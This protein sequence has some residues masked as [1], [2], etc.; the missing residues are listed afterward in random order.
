M[1]IEKKLWIALI[2]FGVFAVAFSGWIFAR[3]TDRESLV[4]DNTVRLET[5]EKTEDEIKTQNLV[6]PEEFDIPRSLLFKTT[7]TAVEILLDGELIYQYGNEANA[8]KFMK[9][10]G[11]CWHIVDIPKDSAGKK[12]EVRI[13]PAY[14]GYYG[15]EMVLFLG[16]KGDCILKILS[17]SLPIF[18]ISCGILF[19]GLISVFLYFA[20]LKN[21]RKRK[22]EGKN[23]IF[24][25]LG[26][27]SLLIALWSL[28]QCGFMQFLIP[29]GRTLYFVDF[30][31]FFLFPVPFNFLVYDICRSKYRRAALYFPMSYLLNMAVAVLLQC[32]GIVDIF[33][34]LP[35]THVLMAGN[36]IYTFALIHYEAKAKNNIAAKEFQYPLYIVLGFGVAEMIL[37][38]ARQFQTTSIFLPLGTM[39]FIIALIWIQVS[40]YYDQYVQKQKLLYLH[41]IA[42]KD[43]LTDAMNRNAYER[44][45][46]KLDEQTL[47]LQKT[48]VVLFDLDNLKVINDNFGHEKGDEALRLCYNCIC[49]I[50]NERENCFRIGGDE[51]AYVYHSDEKELI[52]DRIKRLDKLLEEA[53]KKVSYPLSVS[54]GYAYYLPDSDSAFKD[55]AKRSDIMLYR[56]KRRKKLNRASREQT[57]PYMEKNRDE[58]V[59]ESFREKEYQEIMPEELCK[60]IDLISPS[61][62]D[63]LYLIDFR[64]DFYYIA[65]QAMERF[66]IG[67]NAFHNVMEYHRE[68]VYGPDYPL[69]KAEFA[70]L[71]STDRCAHNMEYRWMDLKREPIWINCRGYVV[72]DENMK[73][74][75]MVGC[76]N[77]IGARQK[78]DYVSGLLGET[79]LREYLKKLKPPFENG[80]LIRLGLDHFK[81]INENLGWEYGDQVLRETAVCISGCMSENQ[82]VYRLFSD[83]FMIL[84]LSSRSVKE[85]KKL[86]DKVRESVDQFIR[87]N[88]YTVMFTISGGIL[89]LHAIEEMG[90]SAAMKLTD[91]SLNEAKKLGRNRCY[92]FEEKEYRQFLRRSELKQELRNAVINDFKGFTAFYQPVFR[93]ETGKLYGAEALMRFISEKFGMVSPA[94]FIPILEETGLIIP[95]GRWM[96]GEAMGKCSQI[97]EVLPKFLV[98]IN[99]SQVQAAKSDV[100]LDVIAAME[101]AKL[102]ADALIIELTESDLLEQNIN[103]RHFLTEL[104]R[105]KIKLALDDFGTGYSNF[106]YLSELG[107]AIIKIDRSFTASAVADEGEYY[108]LNQF[109]SMI[110]NLNLKLCIEGVENKEEWSKIRNLQ[111]DFSQGF[112]W[113]RPCPYEEFVEKFVEK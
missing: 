48:G 97:R 94:E 37:Y 1:K 6:L 105:M 42:N 41:K 22:I 31:T 73:P 24:L 91:F 10:P 61:T 13:L 52:A 4:F 92:V 57:A 45:I 103:E 87:D 82:T 64:T 54:A 47:Q 72:R 68:F 16:T 98:S 95:A 106:H 74:L 5:E 35:V 56:H 60:V 49:Q 29:D 83:E 69:L 111:P 28:Q 27:F 88:E 65:P 43:M 113:G 38:Y 99:I 7:H 58:A 21:K 46:Q 86:Y 112:F 50:F 85:V 90:D 20:T 89:P 63:Y 102:P 33:Q 36:V 70:D 75:Y 2:L 23:E 53:A 96:M 66:C 9:S 32:A 93:S 12:M 30:F 17:S 51:F 78:A 15:N 11:S 76:I 59:R 67:K 55:I 8:P 14:P 62:D 80:Y 18:I 108:L 34:I 40:R 109:C 101:K 44:T 79:G 39:G 107:P 81:E 100:I 19:A 25:N 26:I 71:L 110:H 84:D 77:E 104:Q 3:S